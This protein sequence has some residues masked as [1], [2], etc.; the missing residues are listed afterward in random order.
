M[1]PPCVEIVDHELHHEISRPVFLIVALQ[2]ET[3]R[4]CVE[5]GNL[6]IKDLVESERFIEALRL[7]EILC[8][9]ERTGELRSSGDFAHLQFS[10]FSKATPVVDRSVEHER[11]VTG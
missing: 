4:T 10:L 3:A 5:Y 9:N 7:L 2:D 6:A 1:L 11:C 8:R